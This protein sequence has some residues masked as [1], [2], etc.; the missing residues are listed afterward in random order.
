MAAQ[1]R[2]IARAAISGALVLLCPWLAA[3]Q[4]SIWDAARNPRAKQAYA[5]FV[6]AERMQ[7]QALDRFEDPR[8]PRDFTLAASA[9]LELSGGVKLHE[10]RLNYL[11]GDL[12]LDSSL[13]INRTRDAERLLRLALTEAPDSP[14]AS[15]GWFNLAIAEAKLGEPQGEY[16]AYS[17]ALE[18]QFDPE[19]RATIFANRAES[20]MVAG[21]LKAAIRDYRRAVALSQLPHAQ[22]LA[23]WGLGV[24]LERSGDL[25]SALAAIDLALQIRLPSPPYAS[26]LALELPEVFFV[27][28]Y[29]VH[30]YRA[31]GAMAEARRVSTPSERKAALAEAIA[32]FTAYLERAEPDRQPWIPNA[33][34]HRAWCQHELDHPAPRGRR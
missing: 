14:L 28:D 8:L 16:D 5:A 25:P 26:T 13:T 6:A 32:H 12:L 4:P 10:P 33:K 30:Y 3:A 11:L 34:A 21:N 31:L 23:E 27:P 17:H 20:S 24:A 1:L 9:L 7:E 15:Q 29:D 2:R 18:L 19:V 22:A